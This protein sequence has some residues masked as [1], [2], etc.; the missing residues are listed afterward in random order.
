MSSY[1]LMG[2]KTAP[3]RANAVPRTR[4]LEG[5]GPAILGAT[6]AGPGNFLPTQTVI[7]RDREIKGAAPSP[8]MA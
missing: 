5:S 7:P 6:S 1:S 4:L 3:A 2:G 8:E